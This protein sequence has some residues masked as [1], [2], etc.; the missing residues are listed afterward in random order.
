[1]ENSPKHDY[2]TPENPTNAYPRPNDKI[3]TGQYL[4]GSTLG[5]TDGSY[6][7]LRDV[8]LGYSL[9]QNLLQKLSMSQLRVYVSAKNFATW[10]KIKHYDP[11]RDG[12]ESWPMYKQVIFGL[13]INF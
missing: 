10:S 3:S 12:S 9:P 11:E 5:Y 8:T 4:Y 13:N 7:K 1:L 6:I 2:W